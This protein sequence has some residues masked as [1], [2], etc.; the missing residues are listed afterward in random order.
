MQPVVGIDVSKGVSVG[1]AFLKKNTPYGKLFQFEHTKKG[2]QDLANLL[3][4]LERKAEQR[5]WIILEA[6][7]HYHAGLVTFLQEHEYVTVVV[8]PLISQRARQASL[9]KVKTDAHDAFLLAELFYKEEFEPY[10]QKSEQL[11]SLRLLTRHHESISEMYVQLK[12]KFR[13]ML[14]QVFPLYADVFS[15]LFSKTSLELLREFPTVQSV[16]KAGEERIVSSILSLNLRSKSEKWARE[17]AQK[18]MTAAQNTTSIIVYESHL[19]LM[20]ELIEM[21]FRYQVHLDQ[22]ENKIDGLARNMEEYELLRSIPGIGDRIA[23]TILSEIGDIDQFEHE[24]NWS[25]MQ[26]SILACSLRENS[27]PQQ[28]AFRSA[29]LSGLDEPCT[30][31]C[32]AVCKDRQTKNM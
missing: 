32:D 7:G 16:L 5:P 29:D 10:K 11:F 19:L 21:L 18:I 24:K 8:N 30:W 23:A 28:T 15:D 20:M 6:T 31:P 2:L 25:L 17:K 4:E 14:D 13:A 12:L 22:L 27:L 9:R 26:E 3:Q 1:Q